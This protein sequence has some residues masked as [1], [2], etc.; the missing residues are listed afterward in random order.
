VP[1]LAHA[2]DRALNLGVAFGGAVAERV[3][4][5]S[6][7]VFFPEGTRS[8]SGRMRAFKPGAFELALRCKVP[9][10]PILL[11]G[12]GDALPKRGFVLQGRHEIEVHV[13]DPI[14]F[15]SFAD[16]S[17][18][19]LTERVRDR[20]ASAIEERAKTRAELSRA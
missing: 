18:D 6:R 7:V 13:L 1:L 19:E 5:P 3:V 8:I 17:A 11:E 16:C 20:I 4:E 14:P 15:E 10:Q 9:L 12:S 2:N